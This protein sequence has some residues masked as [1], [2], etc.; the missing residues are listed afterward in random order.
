MA[1]N[2]CP[3]LAD[4]TP[5]TYA[6]AIGNILG[7]ADYGN[8]ITG[9]TGV[10]TNVG[11]TYLGNGSVTIFSQ[12]FSGSQSY[13]NQT[14]AFINSAVNSQTYLDSTFTSMNS[15]ISG[16]LT[17]VNLALP[18]FGS[19]L[20]RLGFLIDPANLGNFGLPRVIG[21]EYFGM[22][23]LGS[24]PNS[25]FSASSVPVAAASGGTDTVKSGNL[26]RAAHR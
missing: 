26:L 1:A 2:V 4:N 17:D 21:W 24:W 15:L 12:V 9:F 14:N 11:N 3:A 10:I 20:A 13:I 7:N 22:A 6:P 19:D 16:N 5:D 25:G 8:S 23:G 18:S